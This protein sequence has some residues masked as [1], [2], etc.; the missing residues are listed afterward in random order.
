[1]RYSRCAMESVTVHVMIRSGWVQNVG[2]TISV[3]RVVARDVLDTITAAVRA[4]AQEETGTD[5]EAALVITL[6]P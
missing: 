1:M 2:R 4:F 5:D 6:K 3:C